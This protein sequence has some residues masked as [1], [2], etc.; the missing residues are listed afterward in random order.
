MIILTIFLFLI[1]ILI[2]IFLPYRRAD[3]T[4]STSL[5]GIRSGVHSFIPCASYL[6]QPR[7]V[8]NSGKPKLIIRNGD[9]YN[10]K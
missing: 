1:F 7:L 10:I 3:L 2:A 5:Q 4:T 9:V 8:N 6:R